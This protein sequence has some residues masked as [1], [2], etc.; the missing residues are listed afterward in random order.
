MLLG[1]PS[2]FGLEETLVLEELPV[3]A[4]GWFAV[5]NGSRNRRVTI[6]ADFHLSGSHRS[7]KIPVATVTFWPFSKAFRPR[8]GLR[9]ILF[10][11]NELVCAIHGDSGTL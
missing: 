8:K 4:H 7:K 3:S 9:R 6:R 1:C 2:C 10:P 11:R 5:K